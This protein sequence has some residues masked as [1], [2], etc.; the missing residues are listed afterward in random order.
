MKSSLF[1]VKELCACALGAA[2]IAICAW[3][4]IPAAVPFTLQT[5]AICLVTGLLGLKCGTVSVVVY[6]LLGAVGL[7]VFSGFGGGLGKLLGTTGG[8]LIG[9]IF[10]ALTVGLFTKLLGKKIWVL[11]ISMVLGIA[12]CYVFGTAWFMILYTRANG[13]VGLVTVLGWCVFP[14]L[15]PDGIK[16][17]LATVLVQRLGKVLKLQ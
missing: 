14:F 7:P 11:V 13:P 5:F 1:T 8:Y 4:S 10:T 2:L 15:I 17:A 6:L 3:I 16:I 9:F 12:L